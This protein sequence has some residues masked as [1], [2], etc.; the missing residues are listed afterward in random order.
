MQMALN[1]KCGVK[2]V[3]SPLTKGDKQQIPGTLSCML[4]HK[5]DL[6]LLRLS[7]LFQVQGLQATMSRRMGRI[8]ST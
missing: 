3:A 4:E 8:L 5:M 2:V 1:P 6:F 7:F